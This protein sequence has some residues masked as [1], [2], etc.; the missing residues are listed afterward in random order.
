MPT[1]G[2]GEH[3][4]ILTSEYAL[5]YR[6]VRCFSEAGFK[7]SVV[8]TKAASRA[9]SMS[10]FVDEAIGIHRFPSVEDQELQQ[11][12]NETIAR[13]GVDV[14]T[15]A[16][17]PAIRFLNANRAGLKA[18]FFPF[19]DASQHRTLNDKGEFREL[20][21]TLGIVVPKGFVCR[22]TR[23]ILQQ[24]EARSL[25]FPVLLKPVA[26][27]GGRGIVLAHRRDVEKKARR[28]S[29][30][31]ILVEEFI[32]GK[33]VGISVLA[34]DGEI[35]AAIGQQYEGG[36]YHVIENPTLEQAAPGII[37]ALGCSGIYNFD[38]IMTPDGDTYLLEC[39]PRFYYRI[40]L[41]LLAGLNFPALAMRPDQKHR[42][43]VTKGIAYA[44]KG[45]AW[46]LLK[47]GGLHHSA[48]QDA[49]FWIKDPLP[50]LYEILQLHHLQ[51][52]YC[53]EGRATA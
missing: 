51:A 21:S 5:A 8:A 30:E 17:T 4:L 26:R 50:L 3:I 37:K 15:A 48:R 44:P 24:I 28:L 34:A 13:L 43:F 25:N 35:V 22:D 45:I 23:T 27:Q 6:G 29:Y 31:P 10:R 46:L 9:L 53:E 33:D 40:C 2:R 38:A 14:V 42:T 41:T 32:R 11:Y 12:L 47:T 39:N 16:D 19:P 20:C 36:V 49:K 52:A 1:G 18:R 7:V